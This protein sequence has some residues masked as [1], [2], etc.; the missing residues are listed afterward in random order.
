MII[1][2]FFFFPVG[3]GG[4][5][6]WATDHA[7]DCE[8]RRMPSLSFCKDFFPISTKHLLLPS[9]DRFIAGPCPSARGRPHHTC[10][11]HHLWC[12]SGQ[13]L[14]QLLL[15]WALDASSHP[16]TF[17]DIQTS[18]LNHC[19]ELRCP[20]DKLAATSPRCPFSLSS[21]GPSTQGAEASQNLT[22]YGK[23]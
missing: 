6:P 23:T 9:C 19:P 14:H 11:L 20:S 21:E 17:P 13:P 16:V 15:P 10:V 4:V 12:C 18:F 3:V 8:L 22:T 7:K 1:W 5:G 2:V